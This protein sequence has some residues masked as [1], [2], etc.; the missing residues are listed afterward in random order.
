[1]VVPSV[2]E[3]VTSQVLSVA[4]LAEIKFNI[5][6]CADFIED[7]QVNV[8]ALTGDRVVL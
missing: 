4:V 8:E 6:V 2:K 5:V 1:M 7:N 3:G